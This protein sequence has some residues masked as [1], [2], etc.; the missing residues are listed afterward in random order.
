[1]LCPEC[2]TSNSSRSVACRHCGAPFSANSEKSPWDKMI[3]SR[4]DHQLNL[5]E[6]QKLK[7]KDLI[8]PSAKDRETRPRSSATAAC[9]TKKVVTPMVRRPVVK[10]KSE[11][12]LTL[13]KQRPLQPPA[14]PGPGWR[15]LHQFRRQAN[16]P[17]LPKSKQSLVW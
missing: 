1:M 16:V 5:P 10:P 6:K 11:H 8:T 2:G 17:R 7:T 9:S 4:P 15:F 12:D 13:Q 14:L 3:G